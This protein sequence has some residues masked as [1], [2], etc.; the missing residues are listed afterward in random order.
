MLRRH[1]PLP[2][3]AALLTATAAQA[4]RGAVY[5]PGPGDAWERRAPAQ[6]GMD[7]ALLDSAVA[8][9]VANESRAPRDLELAHYQTFGREPFG[10]AV[11]PFNERGDPAGIVIRNGYI[12]AEWGD[13][14]RVD[15]TFSVTKSFLSTVVGLAV[16]RGLIRS[17]HDPV[18]SVRGADASSWRRTGGSRHAGGMG[19]GRPLAAVRHGAQPA[20]HLGPPAAAD[21]RLGGHA[22]G[23]ARVGRPPRRRTRRSGARVPRGEPGAAYEYNDVRVNAA[24]ARRAQRV[25]PARCRRCCAKR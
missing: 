2:L 25:A 9:A 14:H 7:A 1:R 17:V 6:A 4:Q 16:D 5:Y 21:Q 19:E 20:H 18:A 23:Q 15:M 22:L 12:V 3:I 10:E 11:G 13:P 24:R 8:F